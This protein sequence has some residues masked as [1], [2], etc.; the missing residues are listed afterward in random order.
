[1]DLSKFKLSHED[2]KAYHVV[3]PSGSVMQVQKEG[4]SSKAHEM[5]KKMA[6]GGPVM[7]A[8]AGEV[9]PALAADDQSQPAP[10]STESSPVDTSVP[11]QVT[12][13]PVDTT[14]P[15]QPAGLSPEDLFGTHIV[16]GAKALRDY[17]DKIYDMTSPENMQKAL[18]AK[19]SVARQD[20]APPPVAPGVAPAPAREPDSIEQ[21]PKVA[22]AANPAQN[23]MNSNNMNITKALQEEKAANVASANAIGGQ[24]AAESQ[25]IQNTQDA[26]NQM[27][28]QQQLIADNKQKSDALL[29]AYADQKIDPNRFWHN[30]ST[31]SKIAAG[32]GLFLG[33]MSMPFTHQG[34]PAI[35][36]MQNAI[37][38]D[39]DAQKNEQGKAHN[40][41]TMN[42]EA[43]GTDL[44]ANIATQNQMYTGLK[45]N[46][47]QAAANFKGPIAQANARML[48][49]Q[50]DQKI[51]MN[52]FRMSFLQ[53]PTKEGQVDPTYPEKVV[54]NSGLFQTPAEQKDAL[55]EIAYRK[56]LK[57]I[58]GPS[59][60]AFDS[61]G[62][63]RAADLNPFQDTPEQQRFE[64]LANTTIK[65]IEGTA[66]QAAMASLKANF[67]PHLGDSAD[68]R[69]QKREGWIQ[70]LQSHSA[71]PFNASRGNDLDQYASTRWTPPGPPA[72][73]MEQH[74]EANGK[75]SL[76][77]PATKKFMG[78][79]K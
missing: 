22:P 8:D 42:R 15:P 79:K 65:E 59:L 26:I 35:G 63:R 41:Y 78:W 43:L 56:N 64:G 5:I 10:A 32:I 71:A 61:I 4:L 62:M 72:P 13:A 6:K 25:A 66:R 17:A 40:L 2:E 76:W 51:A 74:R 60:E 37:D 3:H 31:G 19:Q 70:Y 57:S 46:L 24:G 21:T 7:M 77:D 12:P 69:A 11:T 30:A 39:I 14:A 55:D 1:M 75:I 67:M 16:A 34:N 18:A 52:N 27:P 23:P 54:A 44:A 28:T 73:A 33:G 50:I 38:R 48:N 47:E 68:R 29:K 49:A 36:I 20:A 58:A 9:P 53:G 45:Y